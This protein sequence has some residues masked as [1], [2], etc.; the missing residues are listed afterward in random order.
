MSDITDDMKAEFAELAAKIWQ[1]GYAS[2]YEA[3]I[4]V[5]AVTPTYGLMWQADKATHDPETEAPQGESWEEMRAREIA[6]G[7]K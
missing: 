7:A 6:A 3:G 5:F 2:G 4:M 1:R